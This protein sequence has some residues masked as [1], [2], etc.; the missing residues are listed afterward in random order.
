MWLFTT[1]G[2]F[3]AVAHRD[4][5][6]TVLV[7]SRVREDAQ[8]L[9]ASAGQGEVIETP[10]GDY[11]YRVLLPRNTWSAYLAAAGHAIDYPNFKKA[12]ATRRGADR[13]RAYADVWSVMFQLQ[14]AEVE[15]D[16]PDSDSA[17]AADGK[18]V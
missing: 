6:G 18:A 4:N 7:R 10:D 13:A 11:R 9:V 5:P 3:S 8:G 15:G 14:Q 12:V 17:R 16:T 2:F 1:D